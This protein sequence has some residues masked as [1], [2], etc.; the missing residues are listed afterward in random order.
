MTKIVYGC[1]ALAL[2]A[3]SEQQ[4]AAQEVRASVPVEHITATNDQQI[5]RAQS[6][7][8]CRAHG[9]PYYKN[10]TA[11]FVDS[12]AEARLRTKDQV[13]DRA[14]ALCFIGLKS[15][16]LSPERLAEIDQAY[17]ITPH[18]SPVERA[19]ITAAHPTD[20]QRLNANWRY[21]SLHVQLWAL[22]YV[23][24]LDYPDKMCDVA[25]DAA[26]IHDLSAA[27]FR[28]RATL[29]SKKEVLDQADLILRLDWA[30]TEARLAQKPMP[31]NL[32]SEIIMERHHSLNWLITYM[33]QAWDDV[34]TDT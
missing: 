25:H 19:Y 5:R 21:Q 12:E 6:E 18:L 14:L 9:V 24:A 3:C 30:C 4:P 13:V 34:S 2:F 10:P 15:E 32:N 26:I 7:I 22:G 29:R 28:Q 33:D 16:G 17:H 23:D 31:G 27:Q 20:Q 1:L 8:Y 11:M